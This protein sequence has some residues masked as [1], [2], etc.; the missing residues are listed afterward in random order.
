MGE[1]DITQI[2]VGQFPISIVGLRSAMDAMA[3]THKNKSDEEVGSALLERLEKENYIPRSAREEYGRAFVREFR[4]F[5]GEPYAEEA[6]GQLEV[7]VLGTGCAQCHSLTRIVME[8]LTELEMPATVE[9]VTDINAIVSYN[10]M[11][12]PALVINGKVVDVGR[13]PPR[14]KIRA[15]LLAAGSAAAATGKG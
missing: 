10:V 13:V 6:S 9:H 12:S 7:K 3:S 5:L 1:K 14:D 15:W 11:G 8:V 4:K 2:R